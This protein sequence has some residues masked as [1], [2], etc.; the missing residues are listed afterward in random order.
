M[1]ITSVN[2]PAHLYSHTEVKVNDNTIR[3][4][5]RTA[6]DNCKILAVFT[7]PKGE[8]RKMKT[9]DGGL[10]EFDKTFGVGPFSTYGQPLLNARAAAGTGV[11]TLQCMRITAPDAT[12]SNNVI[13]AQ[14]R[15]AMKKI[16]VKT[17]K[18]KAKS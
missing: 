2:L 13:W 8:D 14:Y 9:I 15:V 5:A 3:T 10:T 18:E 16:K 7:S 12:Y 4:Y 11:V 6:N 17:L 1:A